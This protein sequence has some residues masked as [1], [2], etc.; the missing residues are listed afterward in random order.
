MK[1][2][3]QIKPVPRASAPDDA[4]ARRVSPSNNNEACVAACALLV[5]PFAQKLCMEACGE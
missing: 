2:P 1:L 5:D 4:P 3:K